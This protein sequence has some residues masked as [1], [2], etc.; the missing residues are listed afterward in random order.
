MP[1]IK[2]NVPCPCGSG[3]KYKKCCGDLAKQEKAAAMARE[4]PVVTDEVARAA[5]RGDL[6]RVRRLVEAGMDANGTF[7]Q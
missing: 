3:V 5:Y 6:E 2:P 4:R 7:A 1:K